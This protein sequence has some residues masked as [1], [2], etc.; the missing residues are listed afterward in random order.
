MTSLQKINNKEKNGEC[1]RNWTLKW[2]IY[3]VPDLRLE[4]LENS[5]NWPKYLECD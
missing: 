5:N 3:W 4:W 2:I 1:Q